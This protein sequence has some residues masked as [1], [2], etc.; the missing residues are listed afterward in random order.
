M[1]ARVL[2]YRYRQGAICLAAI[3]EDT[4]VGY[5]WLLFGAYEEDEVRARFVPQSDAAF[6]FDIYV[7]SPLKKTE[8]M[9]HR[10]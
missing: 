3:S 9:K 10:A 4:V 8:L 1:S 5:M 7:N 2:A 6:D